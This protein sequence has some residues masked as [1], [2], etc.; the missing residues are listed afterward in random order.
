[1]EKS[2]HDD[3]ERND[4]DERP[5]DTHLESLLADTC[6]TASGGSEPNLHILSNVVQSILRYAR[7]IKGPAVG[8]VAAD[9]GDVVKD[10]C[11]DGE[12][13]SSAKGERNA[14]ECYYCRN[15]S[16]EKPN[17]MNGSWTP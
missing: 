8:G 3:H 11:H 6:K 16:W 4:G 13:Q 14:H 2:T 5:H 7:E 15:V 17:G 1:M 9:V 10:S 12:G